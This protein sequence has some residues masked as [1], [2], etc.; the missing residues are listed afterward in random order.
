MSSIRLFKRF[1]LRDIREFEVDSGKSILE[2]ISYID[3]YNL[4][5]IIML[6][7]SG[8][9]EEGAC[10]LLDSYLESG[11]DLVSAYKEC[12]ECLLGNLGDDVD[13]DNET[14][15]INLSDVLDKFCMQLMSVGLG[16]SE[17]WDM[18]TYEMYR[19]FEKIEGKIVADL[20]RQISTNHLL[21]QM[22]GGAVWGK[23]PAEP[24]SVNKQEEQSSEFISSREYGE[25]DK[26][27][28]SSILALRGICN[29]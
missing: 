29:K 23:L 17:F 2:L 21:A 5:E 8:I 7:N 3:I 28:L 15:D 11:E 4:I 9:D 13:G 22:I 24:P 14:I 26:G 19:V 18:D 25:V 1:K 10:R 27:T 6:G 16:Y 12:K 20:N